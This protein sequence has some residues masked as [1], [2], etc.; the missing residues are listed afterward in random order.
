MPE[1][2]AAGSRDLERLSALQSDLAEGEPDV[3]GWP[4]VSSN[5]PTVGTVADLLVDPRAGEIVAF[6]VA[7]LGA[8]G[9]SAGARA[10][11]S[12][13][14]AYIDDAARRV[15]VDAAAP[16][17]EYSS[18]YSGRSSGAGADAAASPTVERRAN[19]VDDASAL[20]DDAAIDPR[21]LDAQV[22]IEEG[23]T[24]DDEAPVAGVRYEGEEH[25]PHDYGRPDE[26][27]GPEYGDG[28]IGFD[29]IV[30]RDPSLAGAPDLD[31]ADVDAA[32]A[33]A[34]AVRMGA[35]SR[36]V[37]YRRYADAYAGPDATR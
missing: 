15:V 31:A 21:E 12:V 8:D 16:A 35:A 32:D 7:L 11:A 2:P 20:D 10:R 22:R 3:R 34:P 4:V 19:R 33:D 28:R 6:E 26:A 29:R 36:V 27:Y 1:D 24:V 37:R 25:T 30:S 5:G 13:R 23:A 17:S 14:A 9:T 18:G